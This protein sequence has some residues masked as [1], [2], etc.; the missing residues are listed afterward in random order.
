MAA[1]AA[2]VFRLCYNFR[3]LLLNSLHRKPAD[4]VAKACHFM[5]RNSLEIYALF[6]LVSYALFYHAITTP[7]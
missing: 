4:P 5:G 3:G 6:V 1:G 7:G 2:Y